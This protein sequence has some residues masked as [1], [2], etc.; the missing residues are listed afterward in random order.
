L[1]PIKRLVGKQGMYVGRGRKTMKKENWKKYKR[2]TKEIN[3]SN[4]MK[5]FARQGL[6]SNQE[7]QC[8]KINREKL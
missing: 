5:V 1:N 2:S 7:P 8:V 3:K 4:F 6:A